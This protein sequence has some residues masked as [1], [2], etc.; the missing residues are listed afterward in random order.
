VN[1]LKGE[2]K[3]KP[4]HIAF[5]P[6]EPVLA[7]SEGPSLSSGQGHVTLWNYVT[8]ERVARL[9]EAGSRVAFA[10]DGQTF[11]T[12]GDGWVNLREATTGRETWTVRQRAN[13]LGL[14][15]SPDGKKF[16]TSNFGG[17]VRVYDMKTPGTSVPLRGYSAR[18]WSVAF[19]P[20]GTRLAG[21]SS[22]QMIY[23]WDVSTL[24]ATNL[25]LRTLR[26]HGSEVHCLA[27]SPDGKFL[28]S[29]DKQGA[30]LLWDLQAPPN[31]QAVTRALV[32]YTNPP[33]IFSADG[34][35]LATMSGTNEVT[36]WQVRTLERVRSFPGTCIPLAI[37]DV[38]KTLTSLNRDYAFERWNVENGTLQYS[39]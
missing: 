12:G 35:L 9:K 30:V 16:A 33:P 5:S 36:L 38:H 39:N 29:G 37:S 4:R 6:T 15:V 17:D 20:D 22:D 34:K 18:V 11:L 14:A 25:P 21:G 26:G 1:Q 27:F 3:S 28:A 7:F 24:E 31:E 10:P 23:L 2:S 19:S 32:T 8:G 13:I